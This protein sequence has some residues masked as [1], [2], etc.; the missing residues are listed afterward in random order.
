MYFYS[1]RIVFINR[2]RSL[3]KSVHLN[4]NMQCPAKL[5]T[6]W[7][8]EGIIHRYRHWKVPLNLSGISQVIT[9]HIQQHL[10]ILCIQH[11]HIIQ[12]TFS[13]KHQHKQ[14]NSCS[15]KMVMITMNKCDYLK[16][17]MRRVVL[18]K[19]WVKHC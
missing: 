19:I 13:S 17:L 4:K 8:Q 1:L 7:T 15:S 18:R 14:C 2:V 11:L 10:A 16:N 9:L 5:I 3:Q 12:H 6:I